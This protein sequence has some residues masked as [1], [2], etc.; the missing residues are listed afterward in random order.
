[1]SSRNVVVDRNGLYEVGSW[2]LSTFY[3]V[4]VFE[5][6]GWGLQL[7]RGIG[8]AVVAGL[9]LYLPSTIGS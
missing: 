9:I 2:S 1:V 3:A 7:R 8:I 4:R 5:G 6:V